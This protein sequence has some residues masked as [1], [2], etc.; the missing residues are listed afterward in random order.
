VATVDGT[1]IDA[2]SKFCEISGYNR[3][4]VMGRN[5]RI[6]KSGHHPPSFFVEM[7]QSISE[8][9][10]WQGEIKNRKKDGS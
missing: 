9:R 1:I 3:E 2:Y 6:L 10:I 4:Q 8:G 7:W 5:H